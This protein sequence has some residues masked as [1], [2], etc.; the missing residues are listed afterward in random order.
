MQQTYH[1]AYACNQPYAQYVAVSLK[2]LCDSQPYKSKVLWEIHILTDGISK[3]SQ[4]QLE[5]I[6]SQR[7]DFRL[8]VHII[9]GEELEGLPTER[10]T[11]IAYFR[12]FIPYV[13]PEAERVFYIDTDCLILDD[14]SP[15]F[16]LPLDKTIGA[17]V[18]PVDKGNKARLGLVPEDYY[19]FS[20]PILINSVRWREKDYTP[21]LIKWCREN[22]EHLLFPDLDALNVLLQKEMMPLPMRYN[23]VPHFLDK[24]I[25]NISALHSDIHD[26]LFRP[27]IVHY[28]SCAPWFRDE[29]QH[30]YAPFWHATNR[31]LK[32][33][34]KVTYRCKGWIRLKSRIKHWLFPDSRPKVISLQMLQEEFQ[35][36]RTCLQEESKHK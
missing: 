24:Q 7:S 5:E 2:S 35:Q 8:V 25:F 20:A 12:F 9:K 32:H 22:K 33:P 16:L 17:V 30:P 10:F 29:V 18:N 4:K 11:Q 1:I 23:V 15:L 28:A 36:I 13:M 26:C 3:Q 21:L 6:C 14:L 19:F 27:A 34:A 31:S